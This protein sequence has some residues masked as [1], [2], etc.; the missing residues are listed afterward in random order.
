MEPGNWNMNRPLLTLFLLVPF[1]LI[2]RPAVAATDCT[3]PLQTYYVPFPAEQVKVWA[4]ALKFDATDTDSILSVQSITITADETVICYDHWEDGFDSDLRFPDELPGGTTEVWGDG[5]SSNGCAPPPLV[6]TCTNANDVLNQGDVVEIESSVP[7]NPRGTSIVYDGQDKFITSDPVKLSRAAWPDDAATTNTGAQLGG[8]VEVYDTNR[9]G[10]EFES[11]VGEDL[12][13]NTAAWE[14]VALTIMSRT[15]GTTFSV[16]LDAD[17]TDDLTNL[18]LDEGESYLLEDV[19]VGTTVVADAPVQVQIIT[20]DVSSNYQGRWYSLVPRTEWDNSYYAPMPFIGD[21]DGNT[22]DGDGDTQIHLYNPGGSAITVNVD[23]VGGAFDTTVNVPANSVAD[24]VMPCLAVQDPCTVANRTGAHFSTA[25]ESDIFYAVSTIDAPENIYDWGYT[26]VEERNLSTSLVIGWAKGSTDLATNINPVWVTAVA[27]TT[28]EIDFDGDGTSDQQTFVSALE[29]VRIV[30]SGDNDQTGMV[31][32]TSDALGGTA[33]IRITGVWGQDPNVADTG[34]PDQLDMGNVIVPSPV[35]ILQKVDEL[36]Q[37]LNGNGS[38]DPGDVLEYTI[39]IFNN[40]DQDL[41]VAPATSVQVYDNLNTE[42]TYV[43]GTT[44]ILRCGTVSDGCTPD[45]LTVIADD[46]SPA[47]TQFALDCIPSDCSG[48]DDGYDLATLAVGETAIIT[49]RAS[50]NPDF[51]GTTVTNTSTA[52]SGAS[53]SS[54]STA[55][56]PVAGGGLSVSKSSNVSAGDGVVSDGERITYTV[57]VSNDGSRVNENVVVY[58]DVPDGTTYDQNSP[59]FSTR[60]TQ[61]FS[62]AVTVRDEFRQL[63]EGSDGPNPWQT[64]W[65]ETDSDSTGP[66]SGELQIVGGQL[67]LNNDDNTGAEAASREVDLRGCTAATLTY[68]YDT[69]GTLEAGDLLTVACGTTGVGGTFPTNLVTYADDVT[70]SASHSLAACI[71]DRT[72]IRFQ[73][74]AGDYTGSDEFFFADDVQIA[75]T[76]CPGIKTKDLFEDVAYDNQDGTDLWSGDWTETNDDADPSAGDIFIDDT[77]FLEFSNINVSTGSV[78]SISRSLDLS[79][80]ASATFAYRF[81]TNSTLGNNALEASDCMLVQASNNGGGAFSTLATICDDQALQQRTHALPFGTLGQDVVVRFQTQTAGAFTFEEWQIF[82][83]SVYTT[84]ACSRVRDNYGSSSIQLS[85]GDPSGTPSSTNGLVVTGDAIDLGPN[86]TLSITYDVLADNPLENVD[87]GILNL[88][89]AASDQ[90]RPITAF[91]LD[92]VVSTARDSAIGDRVW[93]DVDGDGVQDV[94]EPGLANVTVELQDGSCTPLPSGGANCPTTTTDLYGNYLFTRL[95]AGTYTVAVIDSTLPGAGAGLTTSPGT[96]DPTASIALTD[97]EVYLGADFG[98]Q[99][100]STTQAIV[101]DRVWSDA[102]A[103]GRQDPGETG[104][105]GVTVELISA[106]PDGAFGTGDDVVEAT[107]TTAA[108]GSY[109]FTGTA[110]G[111]YAVRV[112]E[113]TLPGGGAGYSLTSGPQSQGNPSLPFSVLAGDVYLRADFGYTSAST[114]SITDALW[115]DADGDG[116]FDADETPFVGVTVALLDSSGDVVATTVSRSDGSVV[117]FGLENGTYDIRITDADGTVVPY[118]GTT[119]FAANGQRTGLVV[120]GT[121]VANESFGYNARGAI[122][123]TVFSDSDQDG[124]QDPGELGIEGVTVELLA[125]K[126]LTVIDGRLDL[127]DD[128]SV[129]GSDDG[130]AADGVTVIDGRLD[131]NGDGSITA[132]DDGTWRGITV[133]DG[134]LDLDGD[135]TAGETNGDDDGLA[136]R[137]VETQVTDPDGGFLFTGLLPGQYKTN[138]VTSQAALS[139][140]TQTGDPDIPG[141]CGTAGSFCDADGTAFLAANGSALTLDYGF[142]RDYPD[143]SG[144]VFDDIDRSAL[145]NGA[146]GGFEGVTLDLVNTYRVIDGNIDVDGDGSISAADD[147]VAD[148]VTVINGQLDIDGDGAITAADDGTW[149]GLTV[150][151]GELDLDGDGTAGEVNGDDDDTVIGDTIATTTTDANGDF[152]FT[153][154]PGSIFGRDYR[155]VVTDADGVLDG[156]DLTTGTDEYPV[157]V[158]TTDVTGVDFGYAR[159]SATGSIGDTVFLDIDPPGAG[160]PDGLRG[161][162]EP[163]LAGVTLNLYLDDGDGVY[164]PGGDDGSILATAVTDADGN[165][166]FTGLAPGNYWVDI[167]TGTLPS[168]L[169]ATVGTTDPAA[170]VALSEGEFNED[171]DFGYRPSGATAILGDR[172]WYD[173]NGNGLQDAG[174]VGIEGIDVT[175]IGAGP[176]GDFGTGDDT[177]GSTTTG[178][179]GSYLFT[180]LAADDYV[181]FFDDT[182][183]SAL[184]YTTTPTNTGSDSVYQVTV[185]AGDV[186][187]FLDWGFDGGTV[188]SIGDL[189]W[190]DTDADGVQDAG[191]PGIGGVTLDLVRISDGEVIATTTT[192]TDS[193]T[194]GEYLFQGVPLGVDYQVVVTDTGGVLDG[195]TVSSAAPGTQSPTVGTPDLSGADF[196]YA[197]A[198]GTGSVGTSVW[199]DLDFDGVRDAGEPPIEGV[200]IAV[201]LDVDGD[202]AITAGVDNLL[203]SATTDANGNYELLGLPYG[204]YLIEVTDDLGTL[205]DFTPTTGTPGVDDNGQTSPYAV[206]LSSGSPEIV[207]ADFGYRDAAG[208]PASISGTVFV[209]EDVDGTFDDPPELVVQSVEIVLYRVVNGESFLVGRTDTDVNGEYS[210]SDLPPGDY[211]VAVVPDGTAV[212]GYLQ[213]TQTATGGVEEVFGLTAGTSSTDHDFGFYDGGITFTPVT[214]AYFHASDTSGELRVRWTTATEIGHV[215]FRVWTMFGGAWQPLHEGLVRSTGEDSIRVREYDLASA[216]VS[217]SAAL[218]GNYG[219]LFML[220]D[221]DVKGRSAFHGPFRLG[222]PSGREDLAS[223]PV[224]WPSIRTATE[225]RHNARLAAAR[226]QLLGAGSAEGSVKLLVEEGGIYR[227]TFAQILAA[228][229]DLAGVD[230][231]ALAVTQNGGVAVPVHVQSVGPFGPGGYIEWVA[232]GLDTLYTKT[233]VYRI[234]VDADLALR[235]ADDPTVPVNPASESTYVETYV[236]ERE[237]LYSYGSPTGDPWYDTSILAFTSPSSAS[238]EF[239]LDGRQPG[240]V[241]A[242]VGLWG[243]TDWPQ[244]PDHHVIVEING[245]QL[246]E[247]TFDGVQSQALTFDVPEAVL[248]VGVNT[249]KITLPGDTGVAF[250]LVN[251]DRLEV[252]YPRHF[253]AVGDR[254]SFEGEASV[255]EVEALG[256]DQVVAYRKDGKIFRRLSGTV[257]TG[258]PGDY[259]AHLQG[260]GTSEFWVATQNA[261]SAPGLE[262]A[263]PSDDIVSGEAELLIVSHPDFLS[264]LDPLVGARQAQGWTVDVVDVEQIYA[265]FGGDR[266]GP[267]A[268]RDYIRFAIAERSTRA[269]L[270]VGGDTYDY[271]DYG[272]TG[273]VSFVPTLYGRTGDLIY[274][275]PADGLLTDIEGDEV[276]DA[277]IGRFPVRTLD[278]LEILIDK[279]LEFEQR[280][281]QQRALLISDDYDEGGRFDFRQVSEQLQLLLPAGWGSEE[282]HLDEVEIEDARERL[283]EELD[284]GPHLVS[285]TGHS[286]PT[287]WTQDGLFAAADAL[288]LENFGRPSVVTQWGCWTTYFVDPSYQTLGHLLLQGEDR[289]AAAVLGATT[290][291]EARSERAIALAIYRR[292]FDQGQTLGQ[293]VLEAKQELAASEDAAILDVLVGWNLLGDPTLQGLAAPPVVDDHLFSDGFETGDISRWS[294]SK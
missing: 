95:E 168:G 68:D 22:A 156:Y 99:N 65:L 58:D 26:L 201:W 142:R 179:G 44:E 135:G 164:E 63:F 152:T 125:P 89:T 178:P 67:R 94:G 114:H 291:T 72:T 101:G 271:L 270:L 122:G 187:T 192:S 167:D 16:D 112:T 106:G 47:T 197:P 57:T 246:A 177:T 163:G 186:I 205:T 196:G 252:D 213:T 151:D 64:D 11:P 20:A 87:A 272:G 82:D 266:F 107:T 32:T 209:D 116:V 242:T 273:G 126:D 262:P 170:L 278:E 211:R 203:R 248:N 143:V 118:D 61:T 37:D 189:V 75:A 39:R 98:Y 180:G 3:T 31:I 181:V 294:S 169:T 239:T 243:S 10:T 218:N 207:H 113:S 137:L 172:L 84:G 249:L 69:S 13:T 79:G 129:N 288:Q 258:A 21:G 221:I 159:D 5:D 52:I 158:Q 225:I 263:P 254:L 157:T 256:S 199:R 193:A 105:E 281:G 219:S 217:T 127:N 293:A 277:A 215:G 173:A 97:S 91:A 66:L 109:L 224:Q 43:P 269:V 30:D 34:H 150:I 176:D 78:S 255:Y 130:A 194:E 188:G 171:A 85:D 145:Q 104:I 275:A 115:L 108:D 292:L 264:G 287:S 214:L 40:G 70:G 244:S 45:T 8:A 14:W 53:Q 134:E 76:G 35:L 120:S 102:D 160:G 230:P 165:Y 251:F 48:N 268:I 222:V 223:P 166:R 136:D 220:E 228:G 88:A 59:T 46:T 237:R 96:S 124:V 146:E 56:S 73:V 190:F 282:I 110:P 90:Q 51:S 280:V 103:D 2:P 206:T 184:G 147:G 121:D 235:I 226:D 250:D 236:H 62:T 162:S 144:T 229:L 55:T 154:V 241:Q 33:N 119:T 138:V 81:Q 257:V 6:A 283:Q 232:E 185:A 175:Y 4:D 253:R 25:S 29:I 234:Q 141:N 265:Q 195:L 183:I 24:Y 139:G 18:A 17:G 267:S 41:P 204:D 23:H 12:T 231:A 9:W 131:L 80:C 92:P 198:A 148:G 279:T 286:G 161:P 240:A 245:T 200:T 274:F 259:T 36:A 289:G 153:D 233:N 149:R 285:Y 290:L 227:V 182:D 1:L 212:D 238:F 284:A 15:D 133:I 276:P 7:A 54:T 202:G 42:V 49:F 83:A 132:A 28:L 155:V 60:M 123:D 27:D 247:V 86:D 191:E 38:V 260:G 100:S 174:E 50:L 216:G 128:G 261:L 74:T 117:F 210:F 93:L 19:Q 140:Y 77:G 111:E 208:S 71:S